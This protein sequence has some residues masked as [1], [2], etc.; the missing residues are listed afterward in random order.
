M[1]NNAV[2]DGHGDKK[3]L[4]TDD[5]EWNGYHELFGGIY[6]DTTEAT[7]GGQHLPYG[8]TE[9]ELKDYVIIG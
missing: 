8:V 6:A 4:L 9:D 1:C 3:V 2:K 7:V 5:D